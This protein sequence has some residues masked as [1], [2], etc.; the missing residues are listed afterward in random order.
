MS[1]VLAAIALAAAV[2]LRLI[3]FS[4]KARDRLALAPRCPFYPGSTGELA[5]LL[6][7]ASG[8]DWS[9]TASGLRC[10][11]LRLIVCAKRFVPRD[12][13]YRRSRLPVTLIV[14]CWRQTIVIEAA[15]MRQAASPGDV[16]CHRVRIVGGQPARLIWP[17]E[18]RAP[19]KGQ[20]GAGK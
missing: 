17:R 10:G 15:V 3:L 6:T 1:A 5:W 19:R 20:R 11:P 7:I 18:R 14:L 12:P 2:W 16:P 4:A 13:F 9:R 8:F